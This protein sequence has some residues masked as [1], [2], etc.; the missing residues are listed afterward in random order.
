ML[1]EIEYLCQ[2]CRD[3]LITLDQLLEAL[4]V[5]LARSFDPMKRGGDL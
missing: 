5:L 2:Q 1:S 3:G 4:R